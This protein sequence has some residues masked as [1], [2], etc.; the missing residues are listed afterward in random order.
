MGY[1]FRSFHGIA[2]P[3]PTINAIQIVEANDT[4]MMSC[5]YVPVIG[6]GYLKWQQ[7]RLG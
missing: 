4:E 6:N 5:K 1:N 3:S 7:E 2:C